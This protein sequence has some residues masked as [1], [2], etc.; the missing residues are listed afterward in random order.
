MYVYSQP[1]VYSTKVRSTN[2]GAKAFFKTSWSVQVKS[3]CTARQS[4]VMT[5]VTL[6][7]AI[8][9]S[10]IP[11]NAIVLSVTLLNATVPSVIMKSA[12]LLFA[13]LS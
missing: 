9:L 2:N 10:V 4:V 3:F 7:N 1:V 8:V 6:L 5:S 13:I 11:L 12:I